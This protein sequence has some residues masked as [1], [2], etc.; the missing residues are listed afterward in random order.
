MRVHVPSDEYRGVEIG[1]TAYSRLCKGQQRDE[2]QYQ[3]YRCAM[4]TYS[5]LCS[6]LR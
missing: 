2:R 1:G 3:V 6:T 5:L 4:G